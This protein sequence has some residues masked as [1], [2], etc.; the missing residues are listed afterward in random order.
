MI[1][2][3]DGLTYAAVNCQAQG[4]K[5]VAAGLYQIDFAAQFNRD[6]GRI[7]SIE[8]TVRD[9]DDA[10]TASHLRAYDASQSNPGVDATY[11]ATSLD[12]GWSTL[13]ATVK[14]GSGTLTLT[15]YDRAARLMSGTFSI[16]AKQG[17]DAKTLDGSFTDL[18]LTK[19]D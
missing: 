3:V 19:A 14:V 11:H 4:F 9:S 13:A 2:R 1:L 15:K 7:R 10:P 6:L 8:F 5:T 12:A 18:P 16:V 17:T